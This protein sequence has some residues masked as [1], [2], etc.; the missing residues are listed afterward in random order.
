L[1]DT[2]EFCYSGRYDFFILTNPEPSSGKVDVY[3]STRTYANDILKNRIEKNVGWT[4]DA[5]TNDSIIGSVYELYKIV[6]TPHAL[7]QQK[8]K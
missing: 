7:E 3:V 2:I 4:G 6:K 8:R 5:P 1:E